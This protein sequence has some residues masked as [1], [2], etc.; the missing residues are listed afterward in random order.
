V[1]APAN[2]GAATFFS[3]PVD[4]NAMLG[5]LNWLPG[6]NDEPSRWNTIPFHSKTNQSLEPSNQFARR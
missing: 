4:D 3:K 5:T 6:N 1:N 2:W